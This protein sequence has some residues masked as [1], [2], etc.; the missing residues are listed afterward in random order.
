MSH[1]VPN[2]VPDWHPLRDQ[3]IV[4]ELTASRHA[5]DIERLSREELRRL[6]GGSPAEQDVLGLLATARGGLTARDVAGLAGVPLWEVEEVLHTAA[7]R[8]LQER[9]SL[10]APG[11]R[12]SVYML[13][14]EEL[15]A[16][17]TDY[18]GDRLPLY[19]ERLHAWADGYRTRRWPPETPEYL[20]AGYFRLLDDA[21]DLPRMIDCALDLARHDRMLDSNR[22]RR[23]GA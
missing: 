18:L 17:A 16:G 7:G 11:T 14:H 15:Q 23:G 1:P 8:T 2:D 6:L 9:P 20:L 22:R 5:Q 21:G 12:P 3:A 10:L 19:R 13:G 4:R